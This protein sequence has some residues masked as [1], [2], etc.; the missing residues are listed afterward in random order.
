MQAAFKEAVVR[1]EG[2]AYQAQRPDEEKYDRQ[3]WA[4]M[5]W[6]P[7]AFAVLQLNTLLS[8]GGGA[9][10]ENGSSGSGGQQPGEGVARARVYLGHICSWKE[11]GSATVECVAGCSCERASMRHKWEQPSTQTAMM[12]LEVRGRCGGL[13]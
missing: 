6:Q 9:G 1:S 7:G 3:K 5:G 10:S 2:F 13:C 4:W 8:P 11:I 12:P